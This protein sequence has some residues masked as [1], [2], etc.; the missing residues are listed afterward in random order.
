MVIHRLLATIG[1][2]RFHRTRSR[3]K[4][5][6]GE[7]YCHKR[8]SPSTQTL[9][10]RNELMLWDEGTFAEQA[11][12]SKSHI[13]K[14]RVRGEGP[15]YRKIGRLVRYRPEDVQAWLDAQATNSTSHKAA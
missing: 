1:A 7:G 10:G 13:Q 8:H 2:F 12:I 6:T 14:M 9:V 11:K 4:S 3:G 15:V 5:G